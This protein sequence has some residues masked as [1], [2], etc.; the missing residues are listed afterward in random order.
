M[1]NIVNVGDKVTMVCGDNVL[2]ATVLEVGASAIVIKRDTYNGKVVC[3]DNS[4]HPH[5]YTV[6]KVYTFVD[7]YMTNNHDV[8]PKTRPITS[9]ADW[10]EFSDDKWV[11]LI[12]D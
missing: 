12:E 1:A 3:V 8:Q 11:E 10:T 9:F 5:R 2:H 6:G 4:A 7:G